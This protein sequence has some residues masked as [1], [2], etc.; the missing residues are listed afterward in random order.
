MDDY[1]HGS[2]YKVHPKMIRTVIVVIFLA[3]VGAM[4]SVGLAEAGNP[5]IKKKS[6]PEQSYKEQ[7]HEEQAK[8]SEGVP[9]ASDAHA[10]K[11]N[12]IRQLL[13][14]MLPLQR[15]LHRNLS[16]TIREVKQGEGGLV[17]LLALLGGA[18]LYGLVHALGPGHGKSVVS[19]YF[20]AC[21][22]RR[23]HGLYMGMATAAI[24]TTSAVVAVFFVQMVLDK[25][26]GRGLESVVDRMSHLS[27]L[28]IAFIGLCMLVLAIRE[29]LTSKGHDHAHEPVSWWGGLKMAVVSGLVPCPGAAIILFFALALGVP[30]VGVL[31]VVAM[32]FGMG[33]TIS[34][35]GMLTLC[36]RGA[37]LH[38]SQRAPG[39]QHRAGQVFSIIGPLLIMTLGLLFFW[40]SLA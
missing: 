28:A 21:G 25:T 13:G 39:W 29:L 2:Q 37:L 38:A 12:P 19:A 3:C 35:V 26:M 27:F 17:H 36:G 33:L 8:P 6:G 14:W 9:A 1:T 20:L 18:F 7:V 32:S 10:L 15:K 11:P 4:L 24:H 23:R 5:F 34:A 22:G 30:W 31:A 16:Q 40:A